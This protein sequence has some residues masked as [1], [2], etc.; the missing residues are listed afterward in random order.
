MM[1]YSVDQERCRANTKL[2]GTPRIFDEFRRRGASGTTRDD[3][4]G[5]VILA[6]RFDGTGARVGTE[7]RT[8]A[9]TG[10]AQKHSD[11]ELLTDGDILA[12]LGA[13]LA[14]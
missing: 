8:N 10:G 4:A 7:L 2:F 9:N 3:A 5:Y 6:R 13:A 12:I 11:I 14:N 1:I